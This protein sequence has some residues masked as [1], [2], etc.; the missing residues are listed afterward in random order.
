MCTAAVYFDLISR[1]RLCVFVLNVPVF[2]K[3]RT[4]CLKK[5]IFFNQIFHVKHS[6]VAES[7]MVTVIVSRH[8]RPAERVLAQVTSAWLEGTYGKWLSVTLDT[9]GDGHQSSGPAVT[10]GAM[11]IFSPPLKGT[12]EYYI[13]SGEQMICGYFQEFWAEDCFECNNCSLAAPS[14]EVT[15]R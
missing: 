1:G 3:R 13:S 9:V 12:I 2:D 8:W 15:S 11:G 4:D 10:V 6:E 14:L 7:E 5:I